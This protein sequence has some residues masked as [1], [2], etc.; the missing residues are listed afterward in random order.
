MSVA[1]KPRSGN[2]G[3]VGRER[4]APQPVPTPLPAL[5]D[6]FDD[7]PVA[8]APEVVEP[9]TYDPSLVIDAERRQRYDTEIEASVAGDLF[10]RK[11]LRPPTRMWLPCMEKSDTPSSGGFGAVYRVRIDSRR[12]HGGDP[13]AYPLLPVQSDDLDWHR[14][15]MYTA[16]KL[17]NS[18]QIRPDLVRSAHRRLIREAYL[19][20][21]LE[22][23]ARASVDPI[24]GGEP[25]FL[26]PRVVAWHLEEPD[27]SD[28][29]PAMRSWIATEWLTG[30]KVSQLKRRPDIAEAALFTR[31]LL[32]AVQQL[33]AFGLAWRDAT[34]DNVFVEF[35]GGTMIVRLID[36]GAG[37]MK[38]LPYPDHPTDDIGGRRIGTRSSPEA[39]LSFV[40]PE[41]LAWRWPQ[42][43]PYPTDASFGWDIFQATCTAFYYY[44]GF[45]PFFS[46]DADGDRDPLGP[47]YRYAAGEAKL[48]DEALSIVK[49]S[50][51][52]D[53]VAAAWR[54]GLARNPSAR[55]IDEML[56][57]LPEGGDAEDIVRSFAVRLKANAAEQRAGT[58]AETQQRADTSVAELERVSQQLADAL[59]ARAVAEQAEATTNA[60]ARAQELEIKTLARKLEAEG[61]RAVRHEAALTE[62]EAQAAKN[63]ARI[64]SLLKE[65]AGLRREN[66]RQDVGQAVAVFSSASE[67]LARRLL[68]GIGMV[69]A[70]LLAAVVVVATAYL[71][72]AV[73]HVHERPDIT[74]RA[75]VW[76]GLAIPLA[77][78]LSMGIG[79]LIRG[80]ALLRSAR[81]RSAWRGSVVAS[82]P[83]AAWLIWAV[84]LR[85][86]APVAIPA[87]LVFST[88]LVGV[89]LDIGARQRK[90]DGRVSVLGRESVA[91]AIG[92][93]VAATGAVALAS[94]V[95]GASLTA[96]DLR[97]PKVSAAIASW[98]I[99][100]AA[101][102]QWAD[103]MSLRTG[104][105]VTND[106]G[107]VLA[108]PWAAVIDCS[109]APRLTPRVVAW[110]SGIPVGATSS[111]LDDRCSVMAADK[112]LRSAGRAWWIA[113]SGDPQ[114]RG[115]LCVTDPTS[116][117]FTA[118]LGDV[119]PGDCVVRALDPTHELVLPKGSPC[120]DHGH[121]AVGIVRDVSNSPALPPA[122]A[123]LAACKG[124]PRPVG[125]KVSV[126][127]WLPTTAQWMSGDH[128]VLCIDDATDG[129]VAE[130]SSL[131]PKDCF[132]AGPAADTVVIA[133]CGRDTKVA[134][135]YLP[136]SDS[137]DRPADD[138]IKA[139]C[140]EASRHVDGGV[141]A[142]AFGAPTAAE[143]GEGRHGFLC[144]EA[145][146]SLGALYRADQV[147]PLSCAR[148][149][150]ASRYISV[151]DCKY[152]SNHKLVGWVD[153]PTTSPESIQAA[154]CISRARAAHLTSA[155]PAY[156]DDTRGFLC[157]VADP[158]A[159]VS[160]YVGPGAVGCASQEPS[161][162]AV[163][164]ALCTVS[165]LQV[166][167]RLFGS[168]AAMKAS[169]KAMV[170]T[171]YLCNCGGGYTAYQ[172]IGSWS[173]N[174]V[175]AGSF[176]MDDDGIITSYD[177]KWLVVTIASGG[178]PQATI[179]AI[180]SKGA[181]YPN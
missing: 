21:T 26:A 24:E 57:I 181:F 18:N 31:R 117:S 27:D 165:G 73:V 80:T 169:F 4:M 145:D 98:W 11:D 104:Q 106:G 33:H 90:G 65:N 82:V 105:C 56:D 147:P 173:T 120:P 128:A 140:D 180:W 83:V 15:H 146:P 77:A 114:R 43:H 19:L 101:A 97:A 168:A 149:D 38:G 9:Y 78:L 53:A 91:R 74:S 129:T 152:F 42:D 127:P 81:S 143:W 25:T 47:S 29:R 16:V 5:F 20:R 3:A 88:L 142:E 79:G 118:L 64:E 151:V 34:P 171:Y 135:I 108:P 49:G 141:P 148:G 113:S 137:K 159:A 72:I 60:R 175:Q 107:V 177:A 87:G 161:Q 116:S 44:R 156:T 12:L 92:V 163:A 99:P 174:G 125:T 155:V 133:Q 59:G 17:L 170:P 63:Q 10:D 154:T 14:D 126:P 153:M 179:S 172:D 164:Q 136:G 103:P 40:P 2:R 30:T 110:Q 68:T 115:F 28:N 167:Y 138:E 123:F 111:S 162:G 67:L 112:H 158:A 122:D 86:W 119:Q 144:V 150:L 41:R 22:S 55:S 71:A 23:K 58:L 85:Q 157:Q 7:E 51:L 178:K 66:R 76:V 52:H 50:L 89:G 93:L 100:Q 131:A 139:S 62:L 32:K 75:P 96:G 6:G 166:T 61:A 102:G 37:K 48:L 35:K 39:A 13:N 84:Y 69:A 121:V 54:I 46:K 132:H 160:S 130:I 94:A 70:V 1:R 124:L 176:H 109:Q 134:V 36:F 95:L 45:P 8:A